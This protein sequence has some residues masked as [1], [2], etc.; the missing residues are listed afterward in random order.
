MCHRR[1]RKQSQRFKYKFQSGERFHSVKADD[2]QEAL[3]RL[4]QF[5]LMKYGSYRRSFNNL[6]NSIDMTG[7]VGI[8]D[9][10]DGMHVN[11]MLTKQEFVHAVT[12]LIP[13]WAE[14]TGI[15]SMA[16]LFKSID[17][18]G[19]G[20]VNFQELM[21]VKLDDEE[22]DREFDFCAKRPMQHCTF[23]AR[24][25]PPPW[26]L[27]QNKSTPSGESFEVS[28]METNQEEKELRMAPLFK[29]ISDMPIHHHDEDND[30]NSTMSS[31]AHSSEAELNLDQIIMR[32]RAAG[33]ASGDLKNWHKH[34]Q[35]YDV[36]N[37]GEINWWHFRTVFRKHAAISHEHLEERDISHLFRSCTTSKEANRAMQIDD[38]VRVRKEGNH[39]GRVGTILDP[40]W[41]DLVKIRFDDQDNEVKSY[42][43]QDLEHMKSQLGKVITATEDIDEPENEFIHYMALLEVLESAPGPEEMAMMKKER[44]DAL[45]HAKTK[46]VHKTPEMRKVEVAR[47]KVAENHHLHASCGPCTIKC[48]TCGCICLIS[49]WGSHSTG[50]KKK[51]QQ[52]KDRQEGTAKEIAEMSF[53]PV[54]SAYAKSVKGVAREAVNGKAGIRGADFEERFPIRHRKDEQKLAEQ[55]EKVTKDLTFRPKVLT[56]SHIIHRLVHADHQDVGTRL[57]APAGHQ[58]IVAKSATMNEADAELEFHPQIT[59]RGVQKGFERGAENCFH[60]LHHGPKDKATTVDPGTEKEEYDVVVK[61]TER[62]MKSRKPI[63]LS[64]RAWLKVK[65]TQQAAFDETHAKRLAE[66]AAMSDG[67]D[68]FTAAG[69]TMGSLEDLQGGKLSARS[70]ATPSTQAPGSTLAPMLSARSGNSSNGPTPRGSPADSSGKLSITNMGFG[71]AFSPFNFEAEASTTSTVPVLAGAKKLEVAASSGFKIGRQIVIDAGTQSEEVNEIAGFGSLILKSPLKFA[72]PAGISITMAAEEGSRGPSAPTSPMQLSIPTQIIT[73]SDKVIALIQRCDQV[74]QTQELESNAAAAFY[75]GNSLSALPENE[76]GPVEW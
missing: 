70:N 46:H 28:M 69:F 76:D 22:A 21:G 9:E 49:S 31:D 58:R 4:R 74:V 33:L 43:A 7:L 75:G 64:D 5:L 20:Y 53:A 6:E 55:H 45:R 19:S 35:M 15:G 14:I 8:R 73:G 39:Q 65:S 13:N 18:N 23:R 57:N 54:I 17:N 51:A 41:H 1:K 3:E 26:N 60:R 2:Y 62:L 29:P 66:L 47:R 36:S 12:C 42:A 10:H 68:A 50:C 71:D 67:T 56:R 32:L 48:E 40:K 61:T 37:K 25:A 11:G 38:K 63:G 16:R 52:I 59:V 30:S 27:R 24:K 44:L 34:F 72:H